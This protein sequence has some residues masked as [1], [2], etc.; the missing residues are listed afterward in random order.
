MLRR[1][2]SLLISLC[3]PL[4]LGA[5]SYHTLTEYAVKIERARSGLERKEIDL[6]GGL[7]YVYLE[8]G[9]G[10]TLVL[11]HGLGGNKDN[12]TRV[13]R[14]LTP[15]Y[16][17][18]VPDLVGFGE[19]T[20]LPGA[21]YRAGAQLERVRAL[22]QALGVRS[23]HLGGNSMGGYVALAY[24][25]RYP[26]EVGS[27]WLLDPAGIQNAPASELKAIMTAKGGN[28]L[29]ARNEE[30]F[31]RVFDFIMSDPPYLPRGM[32]DE[33]A[34]ERIANFATEQYVFAQ[35]AGDSLEQAVAGLATPTLIVWGEQDR[36]IHVGSADVL[37][38]LLPHSSVIVM[39]RIGHVPMVEQPAL[40]AQDY[41]RF[42]ATLAAPH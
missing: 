26:A 24:A 13:A 21:D 6:P 33:M 18:I 35:I 42:R 16:R 39:P 14:L 17:V 38:K 7:H 37:H 2:L 20:R 36:V 28:P 25:A 11:L 32:L 19:S 27:L 23:S 1:C 41:L 4:A 8:G 9:A 15:H 5:C 31:A 10:E 34:Q 30:E 29:L 12:F 22:L 3:L 40:T